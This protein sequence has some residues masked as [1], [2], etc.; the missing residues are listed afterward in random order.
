MHLPLSRQ[1]APLSRQYAPSP[2]PSRPLSSISI[3]RELCLWCCG[4][5]RVEER[6]RR[7]TIRRVTIRRVII[8]FRRVII[9][10]R[11]VI[12]RRVIIQITRRQRGRSKH[13]AVGTATDRA[14]QL[15][16]ERVRADCRVQ[17][18]RRKCTLPAALRT[19]KE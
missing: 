12:I 6:I 1:Y 16:R 8:C 18:E 11:R 13:S 4:D 14:D 3:G 15:E 9:C 17:H 10:F 5:E 2:P 19:D 7:V